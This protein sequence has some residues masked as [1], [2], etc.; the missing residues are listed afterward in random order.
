MSEQSPEPAFDWLK[1]FELASVLAAR[2]DEASQ[3]SAVSRAYYA[4]FNV[5]RMVLDRY[6]PEY[7]SMRSRDSHQQVWARIGALDKR[8][9]KN[10]VRSGRGLLSKRKGA[11]YELAASDWPRQTELA[12][13][14]AKRALTSLSDL[15]DLP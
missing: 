6:D 3:R 11:D 2:G 13:A 7:N 9:A 4:V 12:L 5:A 8:Q 1:F 10:A 14:E 15:L